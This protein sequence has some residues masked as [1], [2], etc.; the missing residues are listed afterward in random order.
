MAEQ[1]LDG[2]ALS[3]FTKALM[4]LADAP[5]WRTALGLSSV[6]QFSSQSWQAGT[7][8][9]VSDSATG[10]AN[11]TAILA[12]LAKFGTVAQGVESA[13]TGATSVINSLAYGPVHRGPI[14]TQVAGGDVAVGVGSFTFTC[15]DTTTARHIWLKAQWRVAGGVWADAGGEV[16]STV[17]GGGA[18][19]AVG[20]VSFTS[21]LVTVVP[22][23]ALE[24]QLLGRMDAGTA[25]MTL[26]GT[27]TAVCR[28]E[29]MP[30]TA[31]LRGRNMKVNSG[32]LVAQ[33]WTFLNC[34]GTK[35]LSNDDTGALINFDANDGDALNYAGITGTL[36]IDGQSRTNTVLRAS[37]CRQ[38]RQTG[39]LHIF[40]WAGI[41]IDLR[42][43][44][45]PYLQNVFM[46]ARGITGAPGTA[47]D[48]V[49]IRLGTGLSSAGG[50]I[51]TQRAVLTNLNLYDM[52]GEA[53]IIEG[54]GGHVIQAIDI[55]VAGTKTGAGRAA[56]RIS[57]SFGNIIF[58]TYT[59]VN[60]DASAGYDIRIDDVA[61]TPTTVAT[62][63]Y[64]TI[65][66]GYITRMLIN[67]GQ[68]ATISS[69]N[70]LTR[71]QI[72]AGADN[73]IIGADT[74]V[75][76]DASGNFVDNGTNTIKH[77]S[78]ASSTER[79]EK[80][81]TAKRRSETIGNTWDLTS[82]SGIKVSRLR[83]LAISGTQRNN[84]SGAV[85]LTSNGSGSAQTVNVTFAT[86]EP[87]T[88]YDI[89]LGTPEQTG[90]VVTQQS[91]TSASVVTSSKTVNGF[92]VNM[93]SLYAVPNATPLRYPWILVGR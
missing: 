16:K 24:W 35:I 33:D 48:A 68:F 59:E 2:T 84:F 44:V 77:F 4:P 9:G 47:V 81:G 7:A 60:G 26:S 42:G 20:S 62:T 5:A 12:T 87:D 61:P 41:G 13:A 83:G 3:T 53:L 55:E 37:G 39:S 75:P 52:G 72:D 22:G 29:F 65:I 73:T 78:D 38:F 57:R 50:A 64:N 54:G 32:I 93:W 49:G 15:T 86:A 88:N 18:G 80:R 25:S 70:I 92:T 40:D 91:N 8:Y 31:D 66:G 74:R 1:W 79:Y 90:G 67:G 28:R 14:T 17:A 6:V 45:A 89:I 85:V 27:F 69:A 63:K 51:D 19:G 34:D 56:V 30:A 76:S 46:R 21:G 23:T 11:L 36:A 43:C 82:D 10:A 58:G 71:L